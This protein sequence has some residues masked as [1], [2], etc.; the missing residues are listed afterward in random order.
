M[1]LRR[2]RTTSV[3]RL[4]HNWGGAKNE[5]NNLLELM[6]HQ[7]SANHQLATADLASDQI[8]RDPTWPGNV[9]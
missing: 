5:N 7:W 3:E 2:L 6:D 9:V 4:S 8:A 1:A